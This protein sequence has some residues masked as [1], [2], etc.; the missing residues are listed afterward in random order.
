MNEEDFLAW[1]SHPMT[2]WFMEAF[3]LSSDQCRAT[4]EAHSWGSGVADQQ[5]LSELKHKAVT[6]AAVFEAD[7][8]DIQARHDEHQRHQSDGA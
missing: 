4:W 8:F 3:R 6:F 5:L 7:F 2:Q 1:R